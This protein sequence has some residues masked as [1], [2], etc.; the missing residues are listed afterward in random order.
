MG[1]RSLSQEDPL[2]EGLATHVSFLAWR[3]PW[4]EEPGRLQSRVSKSRTRLKRLNTHTHTHKAGKESLETLPFFVLPTCWKIYKLSSTYC[5]KPWFSLIWPGLSPP[6]SFVRAPNTPSLFQKGLM[7]VSFSYPLPT[8]ALSTFH[9]GS[10]HVHHLE[11][12]ALDAHPSGSRAV[13]VL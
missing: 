6:T 12:P 11:G 7:T 1:V 5:S 9:L 8:Q 3:A 10:H 2:E 4:T 13:C